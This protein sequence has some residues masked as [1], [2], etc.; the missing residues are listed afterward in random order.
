MVFDENVG[1]ILLYGGSGPDSTPYLCDFWTFDGTDWQLV[2]D[3][4]QGIGCRAGA[5]MV[6]DSFRQKTV[7]Y[8][9]YY[10]MTIM[11]STWEYDGQQW[12]WMESAHPVIP[13]RT[14]FRMSYDKFQRKTVLFGGLNWSIP[15]TYGDTWEYDGNTWKKIQTAVS[16]PP[17]K[18]GNFVYM[19]NLFGSIY[20]GGVGD[21]ALQSFNDTWLYS[22]AT[23]Y[24]STPMN[25]K[26]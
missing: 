9:G 7:L 14:D 2:F 11:G 3:D 8:G 25:G 16:H 24:S 18:M 12:K 6:Y 17:R 22:A 13:G 1:K 5:K 4:Q 15:A 19:D 10:G 20:F 21:Y 23:H 26:K